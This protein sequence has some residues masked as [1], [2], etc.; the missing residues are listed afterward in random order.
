LTWTTISVEDVPRWHRPREVVTEADDGQ[1]THVDDM[2]DELAPWSTSAA[3][4][5]WAST[6]TRGRAFG[7]ARSGPPMSTLPARA[8]CWGGVDPT[9]RAAAW[10]VR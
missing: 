8:H 3:T 2:H 5:S 6:T 4:P 7:L 9:W 10:A 1:S